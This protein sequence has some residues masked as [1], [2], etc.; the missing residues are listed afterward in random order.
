MGG[1]EEVL[2]PFH[3]LVII[4]VVQE[5]MVAPQTVNPEGVVRTQLVAAVEVDL[6]TFLL[7]L[8]TDP[9][10]LEYVREMVM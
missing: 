9:G 4:L 1:M 3:Y 6:L 5:D 8:K 7:T 10:D 2:G